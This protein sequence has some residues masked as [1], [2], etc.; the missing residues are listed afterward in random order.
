MAQR[1]PT[2]A[3]W[4]EIRTRRE[5]GESFGALAK[6]FDISKTAVIRRSQMEGWKGGQNI[7]ESVRRRTAE[8]MAG[9]DE[10]I[11]TGNYEQ[12]AEIIDAEANRRVEIELRHRDEWTQLE[13]YRKVAMMKMKDA[14]DAGVKSGAKGQ[15]VIAKIAS[16]VAKNHIM[17][18]AT[19]QEAERKAYR[20]NDPTV[21]SATSATQIILE[22]PE[23]CYEPTA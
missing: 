16:E 23:R 5:A 4:A 12:V 10:A 1:R 20:L 17:A 22:V 13:P 21:V 8:K 6:A 19:K 3:Q 11:T 14:H 9:A 7:E 15:W 18:L 2:A